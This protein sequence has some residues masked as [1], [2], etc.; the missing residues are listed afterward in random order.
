[1][2][3][4]VPPPLKK[5][6]LLKREDYMLGGVF[7]SISVTDIALLQ[8]YRRTRQRTGAEGRKLERKKRKYHAGVGRNEG[9]RERM[10]E[11]G[12]ETEREKKLKN[13]TCAFNLHVKTLN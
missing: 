2:T 12:G 10:K 8:G 9:E 1:M 4:S 7:I 3:S 11:R 6:A 13:V 5:S